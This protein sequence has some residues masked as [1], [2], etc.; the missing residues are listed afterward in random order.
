[1]FGKPAAVVTNTAAV[2]A[3]IVGKRIKPRLPEKF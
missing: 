3:R 1:V 2:V